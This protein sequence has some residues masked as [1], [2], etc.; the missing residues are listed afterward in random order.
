MSILGY[1]IQF[2]DEEAT[3]PCMNHKRLFKHFS[4]ALE[5]AEEMYRDYIL[6]NNEEFLGPYEIIKPTKKEV[7]IAGS[8][9][10]FRSRDVYIWIECIFE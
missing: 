1:I 10:I 4:K 2:F 5:S 8:S 6:A 7:D 9:V 3:I